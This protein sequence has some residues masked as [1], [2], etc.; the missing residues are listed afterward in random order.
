MTTSTHRSSL[1]RRRLG[2]ALALALA[3]TGAAVGSS[4][5]AVAAAPSP[6]ALTDPADEAWYLGRWNYSHPDPDEG[7]NV[8]ELRCPAGSEGCTGPSPGGAL[9]VPQVG[10]IVYTD[11]PDG[12]VVGRTDMGCT[13]R[14]TPRPGG[15]DL[16]PTGQYCFN[17]VYG[18]GYTITDWTITRQPHGQHTERIRALSH[19]PDGD[20]E[21]VLDNGHRNRAPAPSAP[22]SALR[23][24]GTWTYAPVDQPTGV[25]VV[26]TTPG[27]DGRPAGYEGQAGTVRFTPGRDG[28]LLARTADGCTWTL[29]ARGNTAEL[30]TDTQV[31]EVPGGTVTLHHWAMSSDGRHQASLMQGVRD[32]GDGPVRFLM[33]IGSLDRTHRPLR[34][35][36]GPA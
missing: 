19:R 31:C 16:A 14:F 23:Y 30:A 5:V 6:A 29:V 9:A 3:A 22:E 12:S 18:V 13:W 20:L 28:T 36:A 11:E 26:V 10:D 25:N 24:A 27:P 33:T 4:P 35:A 7:R 32:G 15:L 21:F 1:W 17:P 34:S 8:A 2:V